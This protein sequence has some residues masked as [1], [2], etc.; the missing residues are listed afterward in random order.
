M[1]YE[2]PEEFVVPVVYV[3]N[4]KEKSMN[5]EWE[6]EYFQVKELVVPS[7]KSQEDEM[8]KTN[9]YK[10]KNI[11]IKGMNSLDLDEDLLQKPYEKNIYDKVEKKIEHDNAK[12]IF[13][14]IDNE[15]ADSETLRM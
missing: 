11:L 4:F 2:Y 14:E 3:D 1:I 7:E 12:S 10:D 6:F 5:R 9:K 15:Y 8:F 13:N